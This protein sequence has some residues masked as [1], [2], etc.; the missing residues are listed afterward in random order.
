METEKT[1]EQK[2]VDLKAHAYDVLSMIETYQKELQATNQ[3]IQELFN[4]IQNED[5]NKKG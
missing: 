4:T 5:S 1:N 3:A 2:L